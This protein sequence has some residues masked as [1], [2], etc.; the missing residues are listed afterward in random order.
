MTNT[1][2]TILAFSG[3]ACFFIGS[4]T[5]T[6]VFKTSLESRLYRVQVLSK[7]WL[8]KISKIVFGNIQSVRKKYYFF[9]GMMGMLLIFLQFSPAQI[10]SLENRWLKNYYNE[11]FPTLGKVKLTIFTSILSF[12][13]TKLFLLILYICR[14]KRWVHSLGQTRSH[15][16]RRWH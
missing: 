3:V 16:S 11:I 9:A 12:T 13:V 14:N 4:V 7:F 1:I 5:A 2:S 10:S 8:L 6:P 15:A